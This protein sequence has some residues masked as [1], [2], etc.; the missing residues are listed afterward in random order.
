MSMNMFV[1]V[2][3]LY[4][5]KYI[6]LHISIKKYISFDFY[7]VNVSELAFH[8]LL[9]DKAGKGEQCRAMVGQGGMEHASAFVDCRRCQRADS[10]VTCLLGCSI[11]SV[12]HCYDVRT[13]K[14][15]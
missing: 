10:R 2:G 14:N 12:L 3:G 15:Q 4:I 6:Y 9:R 1:Y 11:P 13:Q 5:S 8:V 7:A